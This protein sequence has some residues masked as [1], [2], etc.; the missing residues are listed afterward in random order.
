LGSCPP[1]PT[2]Q[3][4]HTS[5]S[6]QNSQP[7]HNSQPRG[8]SSP[9]PSLQPNPRPPQPPNNRSTRD[10]AESL[11]PQ[12]AEETWPLQLQYPNVEGGITTKFTSLT[13]PPTVDNI[14][15]LLAEEAENEEW[16]PS[17]GGPPS[18]FKLQWRLSGGSAK[19]NDP[20]VELGNSKDEKHCEEDVYNFLRTKRKATKWKI[21]VQV[22]TPKA[23]QK[24]SLNEEA[25]GKGKQKVRTDE[26]QAPQTYMLTVWCTRG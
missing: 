5:H 14:W 6:P 22:V 12:P 11:Q 24:R 3:A 9:Q 4:S 18:G 19:S 2:A 17:F 15:E 25:A 20:W 7:A 21:A 16:S 1:T 13:P 26:V 8:P 10:Q 23:G